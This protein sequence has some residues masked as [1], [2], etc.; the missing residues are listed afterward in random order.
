MRSHI[1]STNPINSSPLRQL[2]R[3]P[4]RSRLYASYRWYLTEG[5]W[6][7]EGSC[8]KQSTKSYQNHEVKKKLLNCFPCDEITMKLLRKNWY[9]CCTYAL[10]R[11]D[12][13]PPGPKKN[14]R[15]A[16]KTRSLF[17]QL[18]PNLFS[19]SF[20]AGDPN[21]FIAEIQARYTGAI[22]ARAIHKLRWFA[23]EDFE[24]VYDNYSLIIPQRSI[25][26]RF[27]GLSAHLAI[28]PPVPGGS[29]KIPHD[30]NWGSSPIGRRPDRS[31]EESQLVEMLGSAQWKGETSW[32]PLQVLG[33]Q[34]WPQSLNQTGLPL[35]L[36]S[37]PEK[38]KGRQT[39]KK[40]K[41]RGRFWS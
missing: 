21:S 29:M 14:Q 41:S 23:A 8:Q 31:D 15:R 12:K 26:F 39:Q 18:T 28:K 3:N 38:K 6:Q 36:L 7:G 1:K 17:Y 32:W 37:R 35:Q 33:C 5:I 10:A 2:V 30:S 20:R 11:L 27:L 22:G 25:V 13:N 19:P 9:L 34:K 16:R 4:S 40:K 24:I